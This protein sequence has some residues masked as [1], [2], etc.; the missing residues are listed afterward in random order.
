M[1]AWRVPR[2]SDLRHRQLH[3]GVKMTTIEKDMMWLTS[4]VT[5][6]HFLFTSLNSHLL[7]LF[8]TDF[9]QVLAFQVL[10]NVEAFFFIIVINTNQ[11]IFSSISEE[12]CFCL[13]FIFSA[14]WAFIWVLLNANQLCHAHTPEIYKWL[15]FINIHMP[16]LLLK[17]L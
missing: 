4:T 1:A 11:N 3:L 5:W 13:R 14:V 17:P 10:C 15:L 6:V 9:L 12:V 2:L 7:H 16:K 8:P